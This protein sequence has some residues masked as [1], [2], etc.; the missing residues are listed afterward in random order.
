MPVVSVPRVPLLPSILILSTIFG[1]AGRVFAGPVTGRV[2]DP[3]GRPVPGASVMLVR[4]TAILATA[5]TDAAGTFTAAGPD[6]GRIEIRVALDGFRSAPLG[7]DGQRALRDVGALEL[8]VSAVTESVLV[9]ASQ[10][11]VPLSTTSSSVS[12]LTGEELQARQLD[13]LQDA[14]RL[15]PGLTVLSAGRRGA[16]TSLFPRGGESDYSLVLIDGVPANAFGGGLDFAHVPL[17]NIDRIEIVRGPQ[18]ALYGANAIG[19]VIR[20]VT[21]R[22]GPPSGTAS[23]EG[24]SFG[25]TRVAAASSGGLGRWQWGAGVERVASEG[26]NGRRTSAGDTVVNDDY[27]RHAVHGSGGWMRTDGAGIRADVQYVGDER[28][29]P[30]PFGSNPAGLFGGIDAVS[31]GANGRWLAAI[32]ASTASGRR[33]RAQAQVTHAGLDGDFVDAFGESEAWSRRTTARLQADLTATAA[34]DASVGTEVQRERAGSTFITAAAGS[35]EVPVERTLTGLFGEVRWSHAA[36]VFVTAGVRVERITR[37]ALAGNADAFAA[38]PDFD[39]DTVVSVNPKIAAAWFLRSAD[40]GYTKVRASAGTGIRPADAFEIAFTDNPALEPERSRSVDAGVDQAFAGGRAL[41][42]AT[43]FFNDYDDLIIAVGSFEGASRYRT[44]N[45]SNARARGL[46]LAGSGRVRWTRRVP[47]DLQLRAAYTLLD[48]GIR[49]VDLGSG[50]PPP[51][52]PGDPLLRRPTHQFSLDVLVHAG[53]LNAFVRGSGRTRVLDTE[54]ST[55]TFGGLFDAPGYAVWH[56]GASWTLRN[57]LE[58]FGRVDNIFDR[59]YEE[60]LG[61]PALPRGAFV[62][63]RIAAGR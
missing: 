22:G 42:E 37:D 23:I 7:I 40:G 58:L 56:A 60:V 57:R 24:G 25:T 5:V 12:V 52:V 8:A 19:S 30:G 29:A 48:T 21:R 1:V 18:S 50:A 11:E 3:E 43:A 36:R 13:S 34:L 41:L 39:E 53:R 28:G 59:D 4:G 55:G 61:Y 49:A 9:T 63:V 46:E 54:P 6:E 20:V 2:I 35:R 15:V 16:Q 32:A 44:D 51:F 10:V 45:I 31:R 14:L 33:L 47:I 62:G 17:V 27:E 26:L 38:R